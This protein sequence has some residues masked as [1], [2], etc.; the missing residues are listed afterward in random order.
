MS[1]EELFDA[2]N[3]AE[4][5][6]VE[7]LKEKLKQVA[8][9]IPVDF[10]NVLELAYAAEKFSIFSDI[11]QAV[12]DSCVSFLCEELE[13]QVLDFSGLLFYEEHAE[14]LFRL[15]SMTME[16]PPPLP[17]S[18]CTGGKSCFHFSC[19]CKEAM[20]QRE[21]KRKKFGEEFYAVCGTSN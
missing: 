9:N 3:A 15:F 6:D 19:W 7:T 10:T 12:L 16:K 5:F 21:E 2:A 13:F 20:V 14:T 18:I 17:E 1:L 4:I 8:R 11:S